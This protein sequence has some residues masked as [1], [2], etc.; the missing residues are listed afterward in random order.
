MLF[1]ENYDPKF[2]EE[3]YNSKLIGLNEL[4][5]V[6]ADKTP[7]SVRIIYSNKNSFKTIA[8]TLDIMN[9]FKVCILDLQPLCLLIKK[10]L[11]F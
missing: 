2:T 8:K 7:S 4:G 10:E 9:D 11:C 6:V 5:Q 3:V 1:Q